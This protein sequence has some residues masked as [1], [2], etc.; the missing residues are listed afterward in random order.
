M[1]GSTTAYQTT[2]NATLAGTI[3][4]FDRAA[5]IR[6]VA[7]MVNVPEENV[8]LT[9]MEASVIATTV[10]MV[11]DARTAEQVVS[12]ILAAV[13]NTNTS[14]SV[15]LG[16]QVVSIVPPV[17]EAVVL[18]APSPPPPS[19]P[20]PSPPP[21]PP[22]SPPPAPPPDSMLIPSIIIGLVIAAAGVLAGVFTWRFARWRGKQGAEEKAEAQTEADKEAAKDECTFWWIDAE[23]LRTSD[24]ETLPAFQR[25]REDNPRFLSQRKI[26]RK[27]TFESEYADGSYLTVSHRWLGKDKD[28]EPDPKGIQLEKI[29]NY[30]KERPHIKW[31]WFEYASR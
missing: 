13:S 10:I 28:D 21:V 3:E 16:V 24:V 17:V 11:P 5:Y 9:L 31:V 19:P 22:P 23:V 7:A 29:R 20:P 27:G 2:F 1:P 25:L 8:M 14:I 15:T 12:D 18:P 30:L 26:T 6:N 4:D